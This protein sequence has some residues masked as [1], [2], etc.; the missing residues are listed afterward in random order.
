MHA[1]MKLSKV[2]QVNCAAVL[3]MKYDPN[4]SLIRPYLHVVL[5]EEN[6]INNPAYKNHQK[7]IYLNHSDP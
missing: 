4:I 2:C 6:E 7:S 3:S 1:L 5:Y